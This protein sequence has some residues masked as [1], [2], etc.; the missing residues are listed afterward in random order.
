MI[1]ED[2]QKYGITL[3]EP[4]RPL[5][6]VTVVRVERS[7]KLDRLDGALGLAK[8]TL[9]PLPRATSARQVSPERSTSTMRTESDT[10]RHSSD[11]PGGRR[12]RIG[13]ILVRARVRGFVSASSC[14]APNHVPTSPVARMMRPTLAGSV[15]A[16]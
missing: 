14:R 2:P 1:I 13:R 6:D 4:Y 9:E 5:E 16:G 10:R 15:S 7:V 12:S 8:G 11:S 3:P